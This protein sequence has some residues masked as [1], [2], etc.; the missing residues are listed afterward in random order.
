MKFQAPPGMR[1]FYPEDMRVQNWLF[2]RWRRA[3]RAFG[4]EEYEGP[5][6]EYLDLYRLKSGAA[7]VSELFHFQD[8][9]QR[10]FA[11]R[12]EMTPTLARMVAARAGAL[13]RPIKWFSLPRMCR[14][15]KPQRGR[16]REFFQW[17]VDILG[18][19]DPLA[20]AEV[21]AVCVAFLRDA[22][23]TRDDVVVRVSSRPLVA[24]ALAGYGIAAA[25]SEQAFEL[26]DRHDRIS[27]DEFTTKWDE[28]YGNRISAAALTA[29][30]ARA[31]LQAALDSARAAGPAGRAAADQL[32][33]L[34]SQLAALG[35]A[36]W[37]QFDLR[38]VRGLAYYTG[39]V[40]EL[41]A[42]QGRLR[43]LMGGG[44][45]DD[46]TGLLGTVRVPG[47]GFGMGDAPVLELLR[48]L[49]KL[50]TPR[51]TIDAFIIDTD[52]GLFADVLRLAGVLRAAGLAVDYSYKRVA[53]GRQFSQA[54]A[55]GARYAIVVGQEYLDRQELAVKNLATGV[56][57]AVAAD[58]LRHDPAG[59]LG[60]V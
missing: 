28:A 13:P 52:P 15:E 29:F 42:R 58:A 46:L 23:L 56:Q 39:T 12:P 60:Q 50:P 57:R 34:W 11:I 37:C 20:D 6:F 3:S 48:A 26:I 40:F 5:I 35:V 55:R 31:T 45:Y 51:H 10:E 2:E 38:T 16:L 25:E 27:A 47:V 7:I 32:G 49:G 14:A 33:A 44:R 54:A 53:V 8:R 19:E 4:F 21:I 18:V 1:D 30:L 24:A 41:H 59:V 17:N 22:G 9:G 43:A 36:D